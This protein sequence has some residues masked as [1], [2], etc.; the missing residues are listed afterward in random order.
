MHRLLPKSFAITINRKIP[1]SILDEN[2]DGHPCI[3]PTLKTGKIKQNTNPQSTWMLKA[4]CSK[5]IPALT[6]SE[7]KTSP[8]NWAH[9]R[10]WGKLIIF[11]GIMDSNNLNEKRMYRRASVAKIALEGRFLQRE[12]VKN[13]STLHHSPNPNPSLQLILRKRRSNMLTVTCSLAQGSSAICVFQ[14]SLFCKI[15]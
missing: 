7:T 13:I 3:I 10:T 8:S 6:Q 5:G 9:M 2:T 1:L 15:N 12:R 14:S 4:S 11:T